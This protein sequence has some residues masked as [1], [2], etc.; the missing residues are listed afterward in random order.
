M[1]PIDFAVTTLKD[2][3]TGALNVKIVST[4]YLEKYSSQSLHISNIDWS[5]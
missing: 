5:S 4:D 1:T 3:G 2:K